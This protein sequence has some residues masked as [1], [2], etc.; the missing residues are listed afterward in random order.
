[1]GDKGYTAASRAPVA[2]MFKKSNQIKN[3]RLIQRYLPLSGDDDLKKAR[4]HT[5][6]GLL[7]REAR[8]VKYLEQ[9]RRAERKTRVPD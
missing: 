8:K 7:G 9:M 4:V 5:F 6:L 3:I 2:I 1:M